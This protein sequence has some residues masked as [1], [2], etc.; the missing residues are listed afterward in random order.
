MNKK[1]LRMNATTETI[2]NIKMIK[3]YGWNETFIKRIA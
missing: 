2:Q 3:L 1:D